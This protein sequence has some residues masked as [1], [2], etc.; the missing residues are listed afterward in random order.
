MVD[1][2]KFARAGKEQESVAKP[3]V[4]Q[5]GFDS[6]AVVVDIQRLRK[7]WIEESLGS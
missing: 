7:S 1:R 5:I 3:T 6:I 4:V 2:L